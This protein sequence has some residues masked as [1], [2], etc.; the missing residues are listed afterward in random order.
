MPFPTPKVS[1]P[2]ASQAID[3]TK[4]VVT[5]STPADVITPDLTDLEIL[6]DASIIAKPFGMED[7]LRFK[8]KRSEF[9]FRWVAY[10]AGSGLRYRQMLAKGFTNATLEDVELIDKTM[11]T[12][13]GSIVQAD[14][15]LMKCPKTILY[16]AMKANVVKAIV[17][18]SHGTLGKTGIK[19]ID[20]VLADTKAPAS[21]MEKVSAYIP[22]EAD[23]DRLTNLM[24]QGTPVQDVKPEVV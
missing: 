15:L 9:A 3:N 20:K 1:S 24:E 14:V 7:G 12:D 10:K 13:S 5:P 16:P 2:A 21:E 17:A 23:I 6:R 11:V 22:T 8:V 4:A 18:G 19:S